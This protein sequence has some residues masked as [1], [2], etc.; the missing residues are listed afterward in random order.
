VLG[1]F[2][3]D[4]AQLLRDLPQ[5]EQTV[6]LLIGPLGFV[7]PTDD[8]PRQHDKKVDRISRGCRLV[9]LSEITGM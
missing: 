6:A 7:Y 8:Y 1:K 3:G 2:E 5:A 4:R 9:N